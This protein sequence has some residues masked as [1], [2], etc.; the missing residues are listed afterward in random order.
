MVG[1]LT[2]NIP[3]T[4][5]RHYFCIEHMACHSFISPQKIQTLE[6]YDVIDFG[7][8]IQLNKGFSLISEVSSLIGL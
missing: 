1:T 8:K 4:R 6:G 2:S 3:I 7:T 5:C